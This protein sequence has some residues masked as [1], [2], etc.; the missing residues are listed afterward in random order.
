MSGGVALA[1]ALLVLQ[2]VLFFRRVL[3]SPDRHI[4]YDLLG[5]HTPLADYIAYALRQGEWPLWDPHPYCGYPLH[6]DLQ[7]QLFYPPAWLAVAARNFGSPGTMFY[8]LEW[9]VALH[10]MLAGALAFGLARRLGCGVPAALFAGTAFQLGAFFASQAQHLG[11]VCG[12]AWLPLAWW[13]VWELRERFCGRWFALLA[14]ALALSF[15]AGFAAV[16]LVVWVATVLFALVV[17]PRRVWC[18]GLALVAVGPLVLV[19]AWPTLEWSA[20]SAASL[21]GDWNSGG[22]TPW[23]ALWSLVWPNV[24]GVFTPFDAAKFTGDYEFTF[25]YCYLGWAALVFAAWAWWRG[26]RWLVG[27]AAV[28][29]V[30][31]AGTFVPG[32][33]LVFGW[34]PRFLRGVVYMNFFLGAASLALVLAAAK[35]VNALPARWAWVVSV[36]TA[37]E[38]TVVGANRPMNSAE[39]SWRRVTSETQV[40]RSPETAQFVAAA[41]RT[42][43]PPWRTDALDLNYS[44]T[45]NA[46]LRR[47]P[48]AN[49][50]N[51]FAPLRLLELRRL[52]CSG[53]WWERQLPV[54]RPE[55]PWLDY[56]NVGY[57]LAYAGREDVAALERA[58]WRAAGVAANGTRLYRNAEAMPRFFV[59]GSAVTALER[60][61]L[62][63]SAVVERDVA[64]PPAASGGEVG[65]VVVRR[66]GL[67]RVELDVQGPGLLV[68]SETYHPGW[69][70]RVNGEEREVLRVNTAFRG[71]V[72]GPGRHAVVMSYEPGGFWW[73]FAV[74]A[75]S[76]VAA[77]G[78]VIKF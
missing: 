69:R 35:G 53:N 2:P 55:S 40:D 19:Q 26:E 54:A 31:Q 73:M 34:L 59:V 49:G 39:E 12:M 67:N 32:F 41:V 29:F 61:D 18:V 16:T 75:V 38:L 57:L 30:L 65:N 48:T 76:W 63:R 4:P 51:P 42:Q 5:F 36:W 37:V 21:R 60:V 68:S 10:M 13:A 50:D 6:A 71:L 14:L 64:L 43:T 52:F 9:L 17:A 28:F 56:L 25:L 22:G 20:W 3:I 45:M 70:A 47:L 33:A 27:L 8:W 11:A 74:S 46:S 62:R 1:L 24:H 77:L 7:A 78:V 58:G 44:F 66:Y 72:V 15:L 23:R